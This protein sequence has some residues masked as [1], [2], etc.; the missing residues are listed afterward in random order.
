MS[1]FSKRMRRPTL[2]VGSSGRTVSVN[3]VTETPSK[4]AA[5]RAERS[6]P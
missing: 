3:V 1:F 4:V 5:S 6:P 2:S